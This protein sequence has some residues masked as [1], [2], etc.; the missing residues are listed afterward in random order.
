MTT[1]ITAHSGCEQTP[2]DSMESVHA[3]I[4]YGADALEVDVRRDN[5]GILRISHNLRSP[6]EYENALPLSKVF[7]VIVAEKDI[8]INCDIKELGLVQEVLSLAARMGLGRDRLIMTGSI[9]PP[10]LDADSGI[11]CNAQIYMN[12]EMVLSE[13]LSR[14]LFSGNQQVMHQAFSDGWKFIA[15]HSAPQELGALLSSV[16]MRCK[17]LGV[18]GINM[19]YHLF[20]P[21]QLKDMTAQKLP[22]SVW[23]VDD[24]D[25]MRQMFQCRIKNIT[26]LRVA[27]AL[28]VRGDVLGY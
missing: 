8:M 4:Q 26:T 19:P 22:V 6:H 20:T 23:T 27:Q 16:I 18:A 3:G 25:M 14:E 2:R 11:V 7:E 12:I 9:S 13:L 1:M 28:A 24:K 10:D 17:G 5:A 21:Q 15:T